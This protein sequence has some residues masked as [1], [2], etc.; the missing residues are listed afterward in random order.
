MDGPQAASSPVLFVVLRSQ[1]LDVPVAALFQDDLIAAEV[2]IGHGS[3]YFPGF[4]GGS[5]KA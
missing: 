5:Y 3:A 1:A 4:S 2:V